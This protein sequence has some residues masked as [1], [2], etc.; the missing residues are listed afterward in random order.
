MQPS[1][2]KETIQSFTSI[3]LL[4]LGKFF[5]QPSDP[6]LCY[7][8]LRATAQLPTLSVPLPYKEKGKY[9]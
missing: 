8:L 1:P 4:L 3:S 2:I 9:K 7:L 5:S 6:C